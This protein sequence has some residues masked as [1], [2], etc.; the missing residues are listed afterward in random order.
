MNPDI[1]VFS[2]LVF[3][4]NGMLEEVVCPHCGWAFAVDI[5]YLYKFGDLVHCPM[6]CMEVIV[7]GEV[8]PG[9]QQGEQK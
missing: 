5:A 7:L 2:T 1:F 6:C 4:K 3:G 8:K 9:E